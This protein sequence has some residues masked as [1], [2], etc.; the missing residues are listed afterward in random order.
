MRISLA[1]GM[2]ALVLATSPALADWQYT[3]WG[4][5]PEQVVAASK[6]AAT[7]TTD[8]ERRQFS[9]TDGKSVALVKARYTSGSYQFDV[10]F[11]FDDGKLSLVSLNLDESDEGLL[12]GD[13]TAKYGPPIDHSRSDI[14]EVTKWQ[15]PSEDISLLDIGDLGVTRVQGTL[16]YRP[17]MRIDSSGL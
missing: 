2:A 17:R 14:V 7:A 10:H 6:G 12:A 5:T 13:L 9:T 16:T 8:E 15:T 4:M 3:K 11:L 1:L